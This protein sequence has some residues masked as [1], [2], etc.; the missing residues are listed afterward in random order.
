MTYQHTKDLLPRGM[1]ERNPIASSAFLGVVCLYDFS[2]S[3]NF[4]NLL[5]TYGDAVSH[6][7]LLSL[8]FCLP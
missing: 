7:E 3:L 4:L 6:L 5:R 2:I 8:S 1:Q